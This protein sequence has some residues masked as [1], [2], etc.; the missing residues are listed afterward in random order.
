MLRPWWTVDLGGLRKELFLEGGKEVVKCQRGEK[1]QGCLW[2][3]YVV[4]GYLRL[5]NGIVR[6]LG[7]TLQHFCGQGHCD[8]TKTYVRWS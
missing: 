3:C 5:W 8:S 7:E 6:R 2:K 1:C 4:L